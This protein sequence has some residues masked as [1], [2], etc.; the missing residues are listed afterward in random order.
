MIVTDACTV[1]AW[2]LADENGDAAN[3]ALEY[4]AQTGALVPGNFMTE[5]VQA[6]AKAERRG[7]IDEAATDLTLTEILHLPI[8]TEMPDA[9]ATL[10]LARKYRL[11]AYDAAYLAL[12]LQAQL[13][14]ATI[15]ATLGEAARSAKC[16]WKPKG[17]ST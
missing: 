8:T 1:I 13:P 10:K 14:L 16:A 3:P 6:L 11:T 17:A 5:V 9:H 15:D 4:A 12:A 2:A 7:R